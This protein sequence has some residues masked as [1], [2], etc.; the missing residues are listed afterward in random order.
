MEGFITAIVDE[1]PRV[2]RKQKKWFIAG[3]C[4]LSYILGFCFVIQGGVYWFELFNFYAAS[5]FALLFLVFFEVVSVS[6]CYGN[7]FT[8][9]R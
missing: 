5:G 9:L 2:L 6:W 8:L 3:V 1:W 7:V 4:I